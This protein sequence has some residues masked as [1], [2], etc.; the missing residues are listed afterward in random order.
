[1]IGTDNLKGFLKVAAVCS[2]LGALT[3]TLLIFIPSPEAADFEAQVMLHQNKRY[4]SKL[5][6]LFIHPQVNFIAGLGI[7]VL[8]YRK[9][10]LQVILGTLFLFIW[11][12]TEMSQQAL[13]ID[14][15]NQFWR[16]G[17]LNA[18]NEAAKTTFET[19]IKGTTAISD[20]Q[21]FVVL[22]GF[23]LGSLFLGWA[24][25]HQPGLGKWIGYAQIFI[26]V[27]SIA[28]FIRYFLGLSFLSPPANFT[29][30]YIYPYLQPLVRV[31]IGVWIFKETRRII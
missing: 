3:T 11:A 9:F 14:G 2:F 19:L 25:I 8:L 26:G 15:L 27:L 16:P 30:Q 28:S 31:A 5:W 7:A 10:P 20:S 4:L 18:E 6:I 1:M 12:Y 29:Y 21:Y 24:L 17:Y 13:L 22:Y 23:G